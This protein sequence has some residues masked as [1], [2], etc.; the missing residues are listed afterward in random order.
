[1]SNRA[2]TP[3][4][5]TFKPRRRRTTHTPFHARPRQKKHHHDTEQ[6]ALLQ[7]LP[8][9]TLVALRTL[10]QDWPAE[11]RT[12][13][14]RTP[15]ILLATQLDALLVDTG[16]TRV[17]LRRL[18]Q[19]QIRVIKLPSG[20]TAYVM[21]E[22][23]YTNHG[24]F[25][26]VLREAR[27][28]WVPRH[29]VEDAVG[30]DAASNLVRQGYLTMRDEDSFFFAIPSMGA[31]LRERKKGNSQ[32][33]SILRKAPY[34]EMLLNDLEARTLSNTCFT[35]RWHVR[36]VVGSDDAEAVATTAGVLVRFK[37]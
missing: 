25:A 1:M 20:A 19:H 21:D 17:E 24:A 22:D 14:P 3:L 8:C 9:D 33:L 27:D 23:Y 2:L 15:P 37:T 13:L 30:E 34:K 35:A 6:D 36:D 28:T 12:R 31:F 11:A 10:R 29:V 32:I 4:T 26:D 7:A 16:N 5:P 18:T